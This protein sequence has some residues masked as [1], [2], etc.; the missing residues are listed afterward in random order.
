MDLV[1]PALRF[2]EIVFDLIT[3]T[4]L[5]TGLIASIIAFL[6]MKSLLFLRSYNSSNINFISDL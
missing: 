4:G 2:D 3:I 1:T 5:L 6:F